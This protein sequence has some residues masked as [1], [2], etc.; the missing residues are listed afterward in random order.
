MPRGRP[1]NLPR[2]Q[3]LDAGFKTYDDSAN[4]CFCGCTARYT[5]NAQC[6]DCVIAK[7]KARYAAMTPDQRAELAAKDHAR[8]LARLRA[9][10]A[11]K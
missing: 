6:V 2:R 11:P 5:V 1:P 3:A 10:R 4:P 8:Y 7:A 9:N